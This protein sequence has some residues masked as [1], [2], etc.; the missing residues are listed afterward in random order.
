[1]YIELFSQPKRLRVL[2][3]TATHR[4][5]RTWEILRGNISPLSSSFTP[6][7]IDKIHIVFHESLQ[8]C[9][10]YPHDLI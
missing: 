6:N 3:L 5:S 9:S 2:S 1:M 4:L 7:G 10:S 8:S